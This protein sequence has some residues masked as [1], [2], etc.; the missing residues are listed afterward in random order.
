MYGSIK[1]L[2][3]LGVR[4]LLFTE[5]QHVRECQ[6]LRPLLWLRRVSSLPSPLPTSQP[7]SLAVATFGDESRP[8]ARVTEAE[9][10]ALAEAR[11][12]DITGLRHVIM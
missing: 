6:P 1:R 3:K 12:L 4:E 11:G 9:Y 8:Y 2:I 7:M 10:M 5:S